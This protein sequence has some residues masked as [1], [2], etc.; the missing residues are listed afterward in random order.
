[1][2]SIDVMSELSA[3]NFCHGVVA[4]AALVV[5]CKLGR[6]WV[7]IRLGKLIS[8]AS[9]MIFR[10]S[11]SHNKKVPQ[12]LRQTDENERVDCGNNL[13]KIGYEVFSSIRREDCTAVAHDFVD[14]YS[15]EEIPDEQERNCQDK[16]VEGNFELFSQ[17]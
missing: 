16:D 8:T 14:G 15:I 11:Q 9:V 17:S 3:S 2:Q 13:G 10:A 7:G 6:C 12:V 5:S 1:M 4:T